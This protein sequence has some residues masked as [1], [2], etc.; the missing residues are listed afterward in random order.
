MLITKPLR[1]LQNMHTQKVINKNMTEISTFSTF[2][3]LMFIKLIC[4]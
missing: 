2:T 3:V 1:K 4:P